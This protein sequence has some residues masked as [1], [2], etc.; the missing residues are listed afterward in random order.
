MEKKHLL[1][2]IYLAVCFYG[3]NALARV[4]LPEGIDILVGFPVSVFVM[5]L[6]TVYYLEKFAKK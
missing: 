5:Y 3:I 2:F 6:G 4:L 1:L